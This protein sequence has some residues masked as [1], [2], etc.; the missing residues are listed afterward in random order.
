M[1]LSNLENIS[2]EDVAKIE[3]HLLKCKGEEMMIRN[4][5]E[6]NLIQE[7]PSVIS[8]EDIN[9]MNQRAIATALTNIRA[10][11]EKIMEKKLFK[12]RNEHEILINWVADSKR[13]NMRCN[14]GQVMK[15]LPTD[16]LI[17]SHS[18][19]EWF[20]DSI[21]VII[22]HIIAMFSIP[23]TKLPL[24]L[25]LTYLLH[26]GIPPEMSTIPSEKACTERLMRLDEIDLFFLKNDHK[27]MEKKTEYGFDI[28]VY[29]CTDGSTYFSENH[30]V[31]LITM[32]EN[33]VPTLKLLTT[34]MAASK[35][36]QRCGTKLC[37]SCFV[38]IH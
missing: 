18:N 27:Q 15:E 29:S 9:C 16:P 1:K 21:F 28:M 34:T 33:N 8:I 13:Y 37:I 22:H 23:T 11:T 32:L 19:K 5:L 3:Y 14:V 30:Q 17:S 4:D 31:I 6:K 12:K 10:V 35:T 26:F 38:S 24:L 20:Q 25:C 2:I 36:L 7:N